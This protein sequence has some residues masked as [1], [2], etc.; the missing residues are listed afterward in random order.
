[1]YH[2]VGHAVKHANTCC[3]IFFKTCEA[4]FVSR[5]FTLVGTQLCAVVFKFSSVTKGTK[6]GPN[7]TD[8]I[9]CNIERS[10][11]AL[12]PYKMQPIKS[13]KLRCPPRRRR[14][15]AL[16]RSLEK[17]MFVASAS[18]IL[19]GE[20]LAA[21]AQMNVESR[22]AGSTHQRASSNSQGFANGSRERGFLLCTGL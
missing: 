18:N 9:L 11:V 1:M 5:A 22:S 7:G 19:R 8:V 21:A 6:H 13:S 4:H 3:I 12:Y 15:C 20:Q 10:C 16:R 14:F 2:A 17:S